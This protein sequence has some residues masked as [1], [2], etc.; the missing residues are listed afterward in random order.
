MGAPEDLDIALDRHMQWTDE[1]LVKYRS[2]WCRQWLKRASQLEA[3]EKAD[4]AESIQYPDL[5]VLKLLREGATLA[6]EVERCDIFERQ[7]KP[8]LLTVEQLEAGAARRN[9]AI[10]AMTTSSGDA[11]LDSRLLAET[12]EEIERGWARGPYKLAELP[13]GSVISRRFPLA[14]SNKVRLID[15]FSVSGVNDSCVIHSKIKSAHD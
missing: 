10:M 7:F 3:E 14:Q 12:Q 15:D 13:P 11:D 1:Q 2:D 9:Q 4:R 6:G 8:C 5:E